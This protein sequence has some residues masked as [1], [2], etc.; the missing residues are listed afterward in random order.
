MKY[1]N[2]RIPLVLCIL[3]C[4]LIAVIGY[5]WYTLRPQKVPESHKLVVVSPH[6]IAFMQPIIHEFESQSGIE[7]HL[8]S[9]GTTEALKRVTY[10]NSADVMW[11]GSIMAVGNDAEF[12]TYRSKAYEDLSDCCRNISSDINC[13]TDVP[14]ILMINTD[15]I[16]S[17]SVNGYEDLLKPELKGRIAYANPATSSSSFEHLANMLYAMG[18]GDPDDG[19]DYVSAFAEQLDGNLLSSS[20]EVYEGVANGKYTVGLT[21]E[22]A[23]I[24]MLSQNKH[25]KVIY[26]SEGVVSTPDGIYINKE[27]SYPQEAEAFVDFMLSYDT[28]LFIAKNLGRRSV[29]TD[30]PNPPNAPA[31]ETLFLLDVDQNLV[32]SHKNE[33]LKRFG[34]VYGGTDYE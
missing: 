1:K 27:T 3:I 13:F 8:I 22:E 18:G 26:M 31:K 23:A 30:V 32:V 9:C 33:W 28:Q 14:S 19:W 16:G 25:V 29:R 34:E 21:F 2:L 15:I 11:G 4:I 17:V 10:E 7:V 20:S 6:P 5:V 24:T 12:Y